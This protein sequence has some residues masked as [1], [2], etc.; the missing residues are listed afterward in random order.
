[1]TVPRFGQGVPYS[2]ALLT[3]VQRPNGTEI[4]PYPDYSWHNSHGKNC[5]G[6]TSVYRVAVSE[7][8]SLITLPSFIY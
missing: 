6:L 3:D 4:K 2:L 7:L 5:D 1:M 8:A